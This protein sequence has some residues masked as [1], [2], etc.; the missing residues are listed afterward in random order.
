MAKLW[1][2]VAEIC[3]RGR[4]LRASIFVSQLYSG[5]NDA[6]VTRFLT[7]L[8]EKSPLLVLAA[9]L[10]PKVMAE[11]PRGSWVGTFDIRMQA[12]KFREDRVR[13]TTLKYATMHQAAQSYQ[14]RPHD[15]AA[16]DA[17]IRATDEYCVSAVLILIAGTHEVGGHLAIT[18][19]GNG[20]AQ[21]PPHMRSSSSRLN[22][23][24]DDD[25]DDEDDSGSEGAGESG[26]IFEQEVFGGLVDYFQDNGYP[27]LPVSHFWTLF[28]RVPC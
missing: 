14:Q 4:G 10:Q 22:Q 19:Y 1:Y 26:E 24:D 9:D 11:H 25:D 17:W 20:D 8:R 13:F 27:S 7:H 21:T 15:Q 2:K 23:D 28:L 3:R 18:Y 5:H 6:R 12:I 16:R